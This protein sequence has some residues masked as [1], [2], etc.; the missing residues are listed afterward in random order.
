MPVCDERKRW[1]YVFLCTPPLCVSLTDRIPPVLAIATQTSPQF[2][3]Q[4][5]RPPVDPSEFPDLCQSSDIARLAWKALH[6]EDA[7]LNLI[8][9]GTAVNQKT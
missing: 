6:D 9:R 5:R 8:I 7:K 3:A 4:Y 1:R 2:L